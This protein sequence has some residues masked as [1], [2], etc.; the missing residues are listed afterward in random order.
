[1][2]CRPQLDLFLVVAVRGPAPPSIPWLRHPP[3]CA[4]ASTSNSPARTCTAGVLYTTGMEHSPIHPRDRHRMGAHRGARRSRRRAG[5]E[6]RRVF[7]EEGPGAIL[8]RSAIFG[9]GPTMERQARSCPNCSR[10]IS[11]DD[12]IVFSYGR[13][14]HLDCRR[15]RLLST[16]ERT[17]LLIFCRDHQVAECVRCAGRFHLQE[18]ASR[19]SFGVQTH[20]CPQCHTDLTDR[21]RAHLYGC[22]MLPVEVRRRAQAAREAARSLA[23]QSAQRHVRSIARLVAEAEAALYALRDIIRQASPRSGTKLPGRQTRPVHLSSGQK[24]A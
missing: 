21:L 19:D 10:M 5:V 17:L 15:P 1:M 24:L 2:A 13:L 7:S 9:E 23:K 14:G 3:R 16:E 20:R 12:T 6:N 22:A 11:S 18:V 4:T 8:R